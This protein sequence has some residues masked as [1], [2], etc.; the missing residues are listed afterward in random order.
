MPGRIKTPCEER[1]HNCSFAPLFYGSPPSNPSKMQV[2]NAVPDTF[3]LS[4]DYENRITQMLR[5]TQ[6]QARVARTAARPRMQDALTGLEDALSDQLAA[7]EHAAEDD[8]QDAEGVRRDR[9]GTAGIAP[10]EG[11][12]MP[13]RQI[14]RGH[15]ASRARLLPRRPL[16]RTAMTGH[17]IRFNMINP[18]TGDAQRSKWSLRMP[19]P[20]RN[21]VA[22][23]G[24]RV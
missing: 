17:S 23:P 10:A 7:L 13:A 9:A 8:E 2:R 14:W 22:R 16:E 12:L 19:R 3:T 6:R 4:G 18:D 11:C 24:Q 1:E 5:M 21:W 20:G 15:P